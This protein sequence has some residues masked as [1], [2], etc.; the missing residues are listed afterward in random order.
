M[1]HHK[2]ITH[3]LQI[4][5]QQKH[6]LWLWIPVFFAFGIIFSFSNPFIEK[7]QIA[8]LAVILLSAF[9]L[10]YFDRFSYRAF[11]YLMCFIFLL[12]FFW[13]YFYQ[14]TVNEKQIKAKVFADIKGEIVEV[15][16][17]SNSLTKN[18]GMSIIINNPQIYKID[19]FG[20]KTTKQKS[21]NQ[22]K[23]KKT[24]AKK[25]KKIEQKK[26]K[27]MTKKFLKQLEKCKDEICKK[28]V[29][30]KFLE[31]EEQKKIRRQE[32]F[33]SKKCGDDL[34]CV[35]KLKKE[36]EEKKAKKVK[37]NNTNKKLSKSKQKQ[38]EKSF[39]NIKDYQEIDRCFLDISNSYQD[40]KWEKRGNKYL[41][42]NPPN[43]ISLISHVDDKNLKAGDV[44]FMRALIDK[45]RQKEFINEFDYGFDA[46]SKKIGGFGY[47]AGKVIVLK[48]EKISSFSSFFQSLRQEIGNKIASQIKGD[49]G[50]IAAALLIGNMDDISEDAMIDI[51]NSGLAHLLSIS[52]LHMAI[53]AAIFFTSIRFLL[54]QSQYLA[55]K[56]D[57]KKIAAIM[58]I[59]STYFYLHLSGSPVPAVRSFIVSTLVLLAIIFDKKIDAKRS[60]ALACL[61]LLIFNPY[62]LFSISFQLS[63]AAVLSLVAFHDFITKFKPENIHKSFFKRFLWYFSEI[64]FASIVVQIVTTPFL[65]Y[66]FKNFSTYGL[67]ANMLAI[68]LTSFFTMP[69]GF[70]SLILMP[71]GFENIVLKLEGY[72]ISILLNIAKTVSSW[73]FSYFTTLRMPEVAFGFAT[74]GF[75]INCIMNGK[76]KW[77]GG[78][79]FVT[80]FLSFYFVQKPQVLFDSSQKFFAIYS[81]EDGLMFNKELRPSKKRDLWMQEFEQKEFKFF[82]GN[83]KEFI[84]CDDKKCVLEIENKKVLILLGRS[85]ISELCD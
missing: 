28:E 67:I 75:V 1:N 85:K 4:F 69:L 35:E 26:P 66:H 8:S 15:K 30:E 76:I 25:S 32:R 12:G 78:V 31:H 55:L 6:T 48:E 68:P 47:I 9:C 44:I 81:K 59:L 19:N 41:F 74:F 14:K 11:L 42:P 38:I 63:F 61:I 84:N 72:S 62:L 65:I 10:F 79:I 77:L 18:S 36:K 22:L 2:L 51:R 83:Y 23:K 33:F 3:F 70:L 24:T 50:A 13:T 80:T 53:A 54:S 60:I 43:K 34:V 37:V 5:S 21:S 27:K 71:F 20:K 52:G 49:E 16:S 39:L 73:K 82:K 7:F 58:A 45:P 56:F 46:A 29:E 57:I 17:F 64:A 40:V